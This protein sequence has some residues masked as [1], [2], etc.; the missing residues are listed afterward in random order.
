MPPHL[1][2]NRDWLSFLLEDVFSCELAAHREQLLVQLHFVKAI[3]DEFWSSGQVDE[4]VE[5]PFKVIDLPVAFDA[6][7]SELSTR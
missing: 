3:E 1:D 5:G 6:E 2:S 7:I 4:L